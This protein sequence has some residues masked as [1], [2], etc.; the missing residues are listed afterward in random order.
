MLSRSLLALRAYLSGNEVKSK[1]I[2]LT[3]SSPLAKYTF[4][5]IPSLNLGSSIDVVAR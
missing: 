2:L 3:Y 5:N 1:T 4:L